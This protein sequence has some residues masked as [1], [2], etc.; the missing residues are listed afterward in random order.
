[1]SREKKTHW[2]D[3]ASGKH[4]RTAGEQEEQAG[5]GPARA[6]AEGGCRVRQGRSRLSLRD[7]RGAVARGRQAGAATPMI[8]RTRRGAQPALGARARSRYHPSH[9][10][11]QDPGRRRRALHARDARHHAAQGGLRGPAGREPRHGRG[12]AGPRARSTWS[13]PTSS[14]PTATASR[15]CATSRRPSP[16]TVVIV[17]TAYGSTQTAVAA[18][19]LGAQ[20]Y[21]IKPFDI[22]ELKIVVRNA[23]AQAA[24]RGGEPPAEGRAARRSRGWTGSWAPPPS[25][26]RVFDLIRSI[27]PT[28]ST[29]LVNGESGTGKELVA[30]GDPRPVAPPRRRLRLGELRGAARDPAGERAV[31]PHE[32]RVHGRAPDQEGPVRDGAPGHAVPRRGG[33]DARLR[34]RSSCCARCRRSGCGAWAPRRRSRWTCG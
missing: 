11:R 21:L 22:D 18:L 25:M 7:P 24:A 12:R 10:D 26:K 1:M 8:G 5:R 31:R 6:G 3:R 17:M 23:L 34:C 29:V 13:S 20:D 28:S 27:A 9:R 14:C 19:K 16:E 32:G 15:S 4:D 2:D 33:R 30:Q